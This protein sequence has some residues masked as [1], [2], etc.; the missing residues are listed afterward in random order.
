MITLTIDNQTIAVEEG[1]TI[2]TAA[3]KLGINI[4]TLCYLKDINV[5]GACRIC[6]VE[7]QGAR[8]LVPACVAP[9]AEGMVVRTATPEV[10][11]T[12]KLILELILSD[13]PMECLTCVRNKNCE[14]QDLAE[15]FGIKEIRFEGEKTGYPLDTSS[16]A[17]QRDPRKCVLCRR[18]VAVC[19]NVQT[20]KALTAENRGFN[21]LIAPAFNEN[22]ANMECVQCGQCSLVCPT[23]AIQ[24][25]DD[26]DKVWAALA[27]PTKHVIVQ[28]APAVRVQIGELIGGEPGEITTGRMVAGLRRLGFDKVFDTNFSA[29]LT[30]MEEGNELLERINKGGTLPM[31]TSCSPG[32]I[33][34][35]EHFYPDL[36]AHLS[37][38]KSPQQMFGALAK[39]YYAQKIDI[40]PSDI[41]SVSIMPCTAKKYEC[42][43]PEMFS[44]GYQ[45]VDVV[46]TTRELGRMFKQARFDLSNLPDEQYDAPLGIGTG[47]GQ[48]F[49][50]SGGV[51]E[52]AL[53]TLSEV[54]SGK[55]LDDIN[56]KA[57]RGLAGVKEATV[58]VGDLDVKVAITNGLGNARNVLDKIRTGEADYHFIEVM[59]CPGG[60]IGGGGAPISCDPAICSK[61]CDAMYSEDER[62]ELRKSHLNPAVQELYR[63]FLEKP[64]GHKSHELLHTHYTPRG[65][66]PQCD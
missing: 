52:A 7:V 37:T 4:P 9:V 6:L 62:M 19:A 42:T 64:L 44:S 43:R 55:T 25:K 1:S 34:F 24:E 20:V 45:D 10:I 32:W 54:V 11:Q 49:G 61:R 29:D 12:R 50:T 66:H 23:A 65:H 16:P 53:R 33:K 30:I 57:V 14:L 2:L 58:K 39:T 35:I 63:D 18:C 21:S 36:L 8:T 17:I 15:E 47:A 60:C 51:T 56:F 31:I 3:Q 5:I 46:L 59:C 41:V 48:I 28:T 13:H 38:C 22:L 26:T 27:D 40:N